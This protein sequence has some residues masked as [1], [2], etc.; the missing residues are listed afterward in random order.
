MKLFFMVLFVISVQFLYGSPLIDHYKKAEQK[1]SRL[2]HP[3]KQK[4][5]NVVLVKSYAVNG[6]IDKSL[7]LLNDFSKTSSE[8]TMRQ[9]VA[10]VIS[11]LSETNQL[12]QANSFINGIPKV[13]LKETAYEFK[14]YAHIRKNELNK[15]VITGQLILNDTKRDQVFFSIAAQSIKNDQFERFEQ[16]LP[17]IT[18]PKNIQKILLFKIAY[19]LRNNQFDEAVH[20]INQQNS[21]PRLAETIIQSQTIGSIGLSQDQITRLLDIMV[22]PQSKFKLLQLLTFRQLEDGQ[23]DKAMDTSSYILDKDIQAETELEIVKI[24]S[25]QKQFD[26]AQSLI[27]NIRVPKHRDA[28]IV[29]LATELVKHEKYD[30]GVGILKNLTQSN[31]REAAL[32]TIGHALGASL[33]YHYPLLIINN[34]TPQTVR[35]NVLAA[36]LQSASEHIPYEKLI[37]LIASIENHSIKDKTISGVVMKDRFIQEDL[38]IDEL[39]DEIQSPKKKLKVFVELLSLYS[40]SPEYSLMCTMLLSKFY[41]SIR[42]VIPKS[43]QNRLILDLVSIP[44]LQL[45]GKERSVYGKILLNNL[46][47]T[48]TTI[49]NE[50][51]KI[52]SLVFLFRSNMLNEWYRLLEKTPTDFKIKSLL[53]LPPYSEKSNRKRNLFRQKLKRI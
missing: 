3:V 13:T 34:L 8:Q 43:S 49:D 25:R 33:D 7:S 17:F 51:I 6:Y 24:L 20:L 38:M 31:K 4:K 41:D 42:F 32:M 22:Y 5:L 50:V 46:I 9:I 27:Q 52:E 36:Y 21:I 47:H 53:A 39:V 45:S 16:C 26:L 23:M 14:A 48:D 28:A 29:F 1:I 11:G 15:A 44:K 19:F 12:D 35:E 40:D 10:A 18:N 30:A 2:T 37:R